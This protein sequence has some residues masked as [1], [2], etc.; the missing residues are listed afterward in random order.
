MFL[1][2]LWSVVLIWFDWIIN[3]VIYDLPLERKYPGIQCTKWTLDFIL[4]RNWYKMLDSTFQEFWAIRCDMDPDSSSN[5]LAFCC[6][7]S[8]M[9]W[10]ELIQLLFSFLG[11]YIWCVTLLLVFTL[12][13][14]MKKKGPITVK[15]KKKSQFLFYA[16][17]HQE[18]L[19]KT[20]KSSI[21]T[22]WINHTIM[23][24]KHRCKG[25]WKV[26]AKLKFFLNSPLLTTFDRTHFI[27]TR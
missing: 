7:L 27:S 5:Y 23:K 22:Y 2:L 6:C 26:Y 15:K 13:L 4:K 21:N 24:I 8:E 25:S 9:Q 10:I 17:E 1:L 16:I 20:S 18:E 19:S 11:I 3:K 12:T 14:G